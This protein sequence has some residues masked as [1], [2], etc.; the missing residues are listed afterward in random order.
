MVTLHTSICLCVCLAVH[1]SI[2][3]LLFSVVLSPIAQ[4]DR[5]L[6]HSKYTYQNMCSIRFPL[7]VERSARLGDSAFSALSAQPHKT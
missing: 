2:C 4:V 3:L 5:T 1:P 7:G 6:Q